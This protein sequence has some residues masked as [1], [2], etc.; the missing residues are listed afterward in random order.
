MSWLDTKP[1]D[2]KF[3]D[4]KSILLRN[5]CPTSAKFVEQCAFQKSKSI[6]NDAIRLDPAANSIRTI[7][8]IICFYHKCFNDDGNLHITKSCSGIHYLIDTGVFL[9]SLSCSLHGYSFSDT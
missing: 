7:S 4:L 5:F 6:L 8:Y 2:I 9:F 3:E 1:A